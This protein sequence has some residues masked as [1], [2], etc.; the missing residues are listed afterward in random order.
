MNEVSIGRSEL[1]SILIT[2]ATGGIG[3]ELAKRYAKPGRIL[4]LWG[5]NTERL[6]QL[7]T[8]CC[9]KGAIVLPRQIDLTDGEA[10]LA[11]FQEDDAQYPLDLI[12]LGAGL[13]DIQPEGCATERPESALKLAQVNYATP[14]ALA[15]AAAERMIPRGHGKISFIGSVAGYYELP[16]APS[17]SSSKAGLARFA[18]AARLG[19]GKKNIQ[20]T[21][22][23]P[24]FVDTPMS[25]RL[26]GDRPFLVPAEKAARLIMTAIAKKKREYIF[27]WPFRVLRVWERLLP[28]I[29]RE[30]IL[31]KIDAKQK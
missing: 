1:R 4:I 18:E 2:G 28:R 20:V 22:I 12:I 27:P 17:Y 31:S 8:F 7:S 3:A 15:T 30:A 14:V 11:A 16:F 26:E 9:S 13:S 23:A 6:Q 24:G 29:A 10:A 21:L 19:W 5:R 25:Q